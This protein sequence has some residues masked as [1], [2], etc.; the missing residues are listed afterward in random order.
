MERCGEDGA[1]RGRGVGHNAEGDGCGRTD[2]RA[3]IARREWELSRVVLG[4]VGGE[5][6][7][8]DGGGGG[9][10]AESMERQD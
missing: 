9:T 2:S 8:G 6:G 3:R 7:A 10:G 1:K 5:D 4:G